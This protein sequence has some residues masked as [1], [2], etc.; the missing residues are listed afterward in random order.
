[1]IFGKG[2]SEGKAWYRKMEATLLSYEDGAIRVIRSLEYFLKHYEYQ[3]TACKLITGCLT[4]MRNNCH[5]MEYKRF[6]DNGWPIGSGPVEGACKNL[7][8]KRMCQSGQR[9]SLAGGQAVLSLRT[10]VKSSRWEAFW[11]VYKQHTS[12]AQLAQPT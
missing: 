3:E 12:L 5:R 1:G 10:I 2:T 8:K 6:R 4:F 11:I 7:V 9:W